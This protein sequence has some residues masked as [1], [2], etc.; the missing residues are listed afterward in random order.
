MVWCD[1]KSA[2]HLGDEMTAKIQQARR[3][4]FEEWWSTE[5]NLQVMDLYRC[6]D[7]YQCHETNRGWM[8]FNA[9]LDCVVIELPKLPG[10][11]NSLS[12]WVKGYEVCISDSRAAIESTNLGIKVK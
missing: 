5:M 2:N 10:E 9:A 11:M 12:P 7:G 4:A 6:Y 1:G 3:A 8:A